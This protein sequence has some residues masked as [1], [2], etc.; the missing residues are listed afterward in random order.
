M[1]SIADA[2]APQI[3]DAVYATLSSGGTPYADRA[4]LAL[5]HAV[6]TLRA[7]DPTNPLIWAPYTHHGA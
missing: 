7:T 1:W 4:A 2:P 3:A 6:D 5:H